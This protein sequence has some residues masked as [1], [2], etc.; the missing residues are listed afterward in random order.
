VKDLRSRWNLVV[1]LLTL[2]TLA[3]CGALQ[4]DPRS[5]QQNQ[6]DNDG[7]SANGRILSFGS[8]VVGNKAQA[9]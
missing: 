4:A 1:V 5:P 8:V 7:L 9:T 3:G 2:T 6:R